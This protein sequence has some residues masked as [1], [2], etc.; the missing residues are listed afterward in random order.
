MNAPDVIVIGSGPNGMAGAVRLARAGLKVMV[1][2]AH[3]RRPGG[4]V[5]SGELTL[6]GFVHDLGAGFFPLARVSPALAALPLERH[7]VSWLNADV[8]SCHPALDGSSASI[9]RL[10]ALGAD[11]GKYFGDAD[12]TRRWEHVARAHAELESSLF[13]ALLGPF[14]S[15]GPLLTLGVANLIRL[16]LLFAASTRGLSQRWFQSAAARRVLP[17]LALH[18]DLGPDDFAGSAMAYVLALTASSVGFPVVR[19]GAQ[20]LID[21][22]VTL[23]ELSGGQLR[24][25][26]RAERVVVRDGRAVAVRVA[27]G[28]EIPVRVGVSP[29]PRRR[30]CSAASSRARI[31]RAGCFAT[32]SASAMA[33]APSRST[34][35]FRSQY[36][37]R[38]R[39]RGGA[40]P[41]TSAR[42]WTISLA[43]P[44]RCEAERCRAS[45]TSSS[46]SRV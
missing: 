37:G 41:S 30:R 11:A 42:A 19:G 35:H 21:A 18:G 9:V 33:G 8:E 31:C 5:G 13:P 46:A 45:R 39:W 3:Q 2:E 34:G 36:R 43:S 6:P 20:R 22:L 28:D 14:P 12:D 15:L 29:T 26:T 16:G 40:R 38:T 4:A 7:G 32:R 17:G 27:G 25:G 24:L 10:A 1:L 23:L 44:R